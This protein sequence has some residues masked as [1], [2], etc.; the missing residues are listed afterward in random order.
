LRVAVSPH[1]Q[2]RPLNT[3]PASEA[4]EAL[5][6]WSAQ[7]TA[8][9]GPVAV[10]Y[11]GGADSTALLLEEARLR[12]VMTPNTPHESQAPLL[13][14]HVHHGLQDAADDFVRHA[15]A[16]CAA[17]DAQLPTKLCTVHVDVPRPPGAS[18]EAQARDARYVALAGLA[19]EHGAGTVLLAQHADD[20]VES[21]LLALSRGGGIAGLAGMPQ[22]F[23]RH[24]VHFARP[25]LSM[26]GPSLRQWLTKHEVPWIEDPSNTDERYTRARL[27]HQVLPALQTALPAFRSTFMRS[28]TLAAEAKALIDVLAQDDFSWVGNPP[29][30]KTLQQLTRERQ[31]NVLRHWLKSE[32]S[33][34]GSQAQLLELLRVIDA[35][36]TRGQGIH[37][38]VGAGHVERDGERL[39]FK[40]FL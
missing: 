11:S 21:M 6:Q 27:R 19:Q 4:G 14:F 37:I 12:Q 18:V 34:T 26:A 22:E 16:F 40:P 23:V 2:L 17:L 13:V 30:I 39:A 36:V 33:T 25:L 10:A 24:G 32:H 31:A 8:M 15:E 1:I 35:C 7:T 29:R 38:R 28:A 9:R 20:Q 3:Y 5:A